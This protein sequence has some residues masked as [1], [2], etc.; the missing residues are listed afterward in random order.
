MKK[1]F[2]LEPLVRLLGNELE[3]EA[4]A[5]ALEVKKGC[6]AISTYYNSM[7]M[8]AKV[9]VPQAW[10]TIDGKKYYGMINQ[11]KAPFLQIQGDLEPLATGSSL[12]GMIRE[13]ERIPTAER[14]VELPG[15]S[16]FALLEDDFET[17]MWPHLDK[18]YEKHAAS[19]SKN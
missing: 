18:F 14:P 8:N 10:L 11:I 6:S 19:S 7:R 2:S 16:H 4:A 17:V 5:G 13:A 15:M 9:K 12:T 1:L 3:C